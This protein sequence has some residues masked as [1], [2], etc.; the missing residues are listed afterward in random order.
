MFRCITIA[1][2]LAV[3]AATGCLAQNSARGQ[4]R[5][6]GVC[7]ARYLM[8]SAPKCERSSPRRLCPGIFIPRT[9][10]SGR[11][12]SRRSRRPPRPCSRRC[13]E[14]LDVKL[15]PTTIGGV[16][17]FV[18][19][20]KAIAPEN[21]NRVFLHFHGGAYVLNPGEPGT[22]SDLAAFGLSMSLVLR[23]KQD[24]FHAFRDPRPDRPGRT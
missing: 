20:P 12:W 3:L 10:R 21:Q 11:S 15:E 8:T 13:R 19:T 18:L 2:G 6:P 16:K 7:S 23:A 1:V 4:G 17:A 14:K 9:S 22:P 5:N 24:G